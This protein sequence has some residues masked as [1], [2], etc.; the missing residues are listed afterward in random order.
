MHDPDTMR[1][2]MA[3][4]S[5]FEETANSIVD[6][7]AG[8]GARAGGFTLAQDFMRRYTDGIRSTIPG[9]LDAVREPDPAAQA[10][11]LDAVAASIRAVS[12]AHHLPRLVER[13]LLV[14]AFRFADEV[15]RRGASG[16]GFTPDELGGEV[17]WLQGELERRLS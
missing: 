10:P 5:V 1:R 12:D 13:G 16:R 15:V 2:R 11:K 9:A 8:E 14:V 4:A 6:R 3:L 17:S 7:I